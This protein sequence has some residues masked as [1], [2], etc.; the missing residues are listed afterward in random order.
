MSVNI[1]GFQTADYTVTTELY[2]GPLDLLLSL[3]EKAELD[4]T[5]LAL[6]EVTDQY[7][8]H[9][10][11]LE[12]KEPDAVSAFLVIAAR[13]LQ[14]KSAALLPKPGV[15]DLPALDEGDPEELIKQ[16]ILYRRFKQLSGTLEERQEQQLR[17]YLRLNAPTLTFDMKLDLSDV[18][19]ADLATIG[20]EIFFPTKPM[21]P[22]SDVVN[23]PRI[24]IR[25]RIRV[26]INRLKNVTVFKFSEITDRHR[27]VEVVVTFLAML[28]LIK[29]N[30]VETVQSELFGEISIKPIT[31]L[32]DGQELELEFNE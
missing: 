21:Q 10:R 26:I 28:E 30:V 25:D 27:K 14:I 23:L 4:I 9:M 31:I 18:T 15:V 6:A 29:Q 22:L 19:A 2:E 3:I 13:L 16:L 7:L 5:R 20:Q 11:H 24:T 12:S 1:R 32:E 17:T 8:E